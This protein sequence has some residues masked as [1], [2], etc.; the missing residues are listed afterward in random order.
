MAAKLAYNTNIT[1]RVAS[2]GLNTRNVSE[3]ITTT[4]TRVRTIP[5]LSNT[6]PYAPRA[7]SHIAIMIVLGRLIAI[8]LGRCIL[9]FDIRVLPH[10]GKDQ[11]HQRQPREFRKRI[12][13]SKL[14]L[15]NGEDKQGRETRQG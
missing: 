12:L 9:G 15:T 6:T 8:R 1:A 7:H 2:S 3:P 14:L 10:S 4:T 11:P 13:Y 5:S